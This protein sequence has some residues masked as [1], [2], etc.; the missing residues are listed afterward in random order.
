MTHPRPRFLV[1]SL[2]AF[3]TA[4]AALSACGDD[5][6]DGTGSGGEAAGGGAPSGTGG[7][8]AGGEATGG[9]AVAGVTTCVRLCAL[10]PVTAEIAGCVGRFV[11]DRQP[12]VAGV[13][14]CQTANE[15]PEACETCYAGAAVPDAICA[16][17]HTTC[18]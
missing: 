11:V 3:A 16:E 13:I 4:G 14:T 12:A 5:G 1:L 7:E 2:V 9:T 18:F 17:A 10:A 15:G 6:D 8:A